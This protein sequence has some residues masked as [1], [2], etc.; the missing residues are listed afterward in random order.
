MKTSK[1]CPKCHSEDIYTDATL[2]KRGDRASIPVSSLS[3]LS[4]DVYV[5]LNCGYFE[6]YV[7]QEDLK[8]LKK[9]DKLKS[10]WLENKSL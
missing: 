1:I 7:S 10:K 2:T 4:I 6:E 3:S 5:C 9:M 8:S